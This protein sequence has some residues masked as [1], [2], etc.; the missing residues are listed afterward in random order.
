MSKASRQRT[1]RE[2]LAEERRRQAQRDKQRRALMISLSALAVVALAVVGGIYLATEKETQSQKSAAAYKGPL[3]PTTVEQ[4]GAVVMA[5]P[6]VTGPSVEL[7]EDFQCPICKDFES[8]SGNMVKALA[9]QGKIKLTYR[10]LAFV[11]PKGS[12]RAAVAAKCAADASRFIQF[13]DVAYS[14]QP[15]ERDALTID[16]LKEFG[17]AAGV[18]SGSFE[19]CVSGQKFASQVE[20]NTVSGLAMLKQKLGREAGTPTVLVNGNPIDQNI[21]FD[22]VALE[23]AILAASPSSNSAGSPSPTSSQR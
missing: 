6:N 17:Q 3:A 8:V 2:R 21:L 22:P 1:A 15:N 9:S 19:S 10:I 16:Q 4:D 11:N 13:H 18:P 20:K 12:T 14:R 7:Y 5:Q 23:K